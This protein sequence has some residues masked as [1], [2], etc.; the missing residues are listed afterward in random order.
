[1]SSEPVLDYGAHFRR[2]LTER[3]DG[4][5]EHLTQGKIDGF[6]E[7]RYLTGKLQGLEEAVLLYDEVRKAERR[8]EITE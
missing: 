4:I 5:V 8:E 3:R 1:M 7:Y 2:Q 6:E